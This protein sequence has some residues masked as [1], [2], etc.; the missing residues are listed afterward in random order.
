M[1]SGGPKNNSCER[2][3]SFGDLDAPVGI[4]ELQLAAAR[5]DRAGQRIAPD[6]ARRNDWQFG[7]NPSEGCPRRQVI[8]QA[9]GNA[10]ADGVERR[11]YHNVATTPGLPHRPPG[12]SSS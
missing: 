2:S 12:D 5:A 10:H 11:L 9:F 1:A 3:G 4:R 8:A 6:T 7:G